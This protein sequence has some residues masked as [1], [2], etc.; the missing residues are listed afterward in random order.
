MEEEQ[1]ESFS[2]NVPDDV[3]FQMDLEFLQC[4]ASPVYLHHLAINRYLDDEAFLEYLK[5]LSYFRRPEYARYVVYPHALHFL[6][7][8][9]EERFRK[10]LKRPDCQ[11]FIHRQQFF[12]WARYRENRIKEALEARPK[13]EPKP[14]PA[15]PPPPS[16]PMPVAAPAPVAQPV[17]KP[18]VPLPRAAGSGKPAGNTGKVP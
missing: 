1:G 3:R 5:Y 7:L 8:L 12:H 17:N 18:A 10:E 14:D 6:E 9:G 15:S 13:E 11:D 2:I 4:L 16:P